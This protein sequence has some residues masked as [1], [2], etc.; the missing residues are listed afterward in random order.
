[1]KRNMKLIIY[2][3]FSIK[4]Y[5]LYMFTETVHINGKI[6]MCNKCKTFHVIHSVYNDERPLI[7]FPDK[8][9]FLYRWIYVKYFLDITVHGLF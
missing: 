4:A 5:V 1:M 8:E 9:I 2:R 6:F 7:Y 3:Q